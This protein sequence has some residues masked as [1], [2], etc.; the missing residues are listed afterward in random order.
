[1]T[2]PYYYNRGTSGRLIRKF[3]RIKQIEDRMGMLN[4]EK[5]HCDQE[6]RDEIDIELG[7]LRDSL[8]AVKRIIV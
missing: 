2:Q 3:D 6:R 4:N 8:Q 5:R 7:T 1:M